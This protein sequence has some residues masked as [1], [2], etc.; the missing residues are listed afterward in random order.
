MLGAWGYLKG[1]Y[2][3]ATMSNGV[4]SFRDMVYNAGEEARNKWKSA[5]NKIRMSTK[6][7]IRLQ[8]AGES[9]RNEN[10]LSELFKHF[11][12]QRKVDY[13]EESLS[14]RGK[15]D[16]EVLAKSK[17]VKKKMDKAGVTSVRALKVLADNGMTEWIP[18]IQDQGDTDMLTK[19]ALRL[20]KALRK[21]TRIKKQ[22]LNWWVQLGFSGFVP[23]TGLASFARFVG[24][25]AL[26][27]KSIREGTTATATVKVVKIKQRDT[28]EEYNEELEVG[29]ITKNEYIQM[30]VEIWKVV[31]QHQNDSFLDESSIR[32]SAGRDWK[33]DCAGQKAMNFPLF[34]NAIFQLCDLYTA[35][36]EEE[37]YEQ[38]LVRCLRNIMRNRKN[39]P[40]ADTD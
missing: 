4:D 14:F 28:E 36:A 1:M 8:E 7:S 23:N 18:K 33:E 30:C 11:D 19:K 27:R 38:F 32:K 12:E 13:S 3:F 37:E 16:A 39:L 22:I 2:A 5:G 40:I 9:F 29:A 24:K 20:R 17:V 26:K 25:S 15:T 34:F 21:S 35:T 31:D 10:S 6:I